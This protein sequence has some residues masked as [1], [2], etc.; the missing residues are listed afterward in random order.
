[1]FL[2]FLPQILSGIA[3]ILALWFTYNQYTKNKIT[4]YKIEKWK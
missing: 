3:S 4:D 1:M 2:E